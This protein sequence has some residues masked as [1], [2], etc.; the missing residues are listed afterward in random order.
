M[1]FNHLVDSDLGVEMFFKKQGATEKG[2]VDFEIGNWGDCKLVLVVGVNFMKNMYAF[3][4]Q[5]RLA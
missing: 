4:W 1:F 3:W 2:E 5:K